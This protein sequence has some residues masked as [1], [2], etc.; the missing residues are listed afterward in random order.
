MFGGFHIVQ[1]H[2][3]VDLCDCEHLADFRRGIENRHFDVPV[4]QTHKETYDATGDE[5]YSRQIERDLALIVFL[6]KVQEF[7]AVSSKIVIVRNTNSAKSN[8]DYRICRINLQESR[9]R[10]ATKNGRISV[11]GLK[12]IIKET[13]VRHLIHPRTAE[14]RHDCGHHD[15]QSQFEAGTTEVAGPGLGS[16]IDWDPWSILRARVV[17]TR[18]NNFAFFPLFDHMGTPSG[19]ARNHKQGCEHIGRH[20]HLVV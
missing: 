20:A 13:V 10:G 19:D 8:D 7:I 4:N 6:K 2:H 17:C 18:S 5:D 14:S 11:S 15:L 3:T 12:V 16:L 9:L 1:G